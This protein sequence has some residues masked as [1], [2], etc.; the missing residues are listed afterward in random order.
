MATVEMP[1][2]EYTVLFDEEDEPIALKYKWF[3]NVRRGRAYV[4]SWEKGRTVY[5]H[6]L[7]LDAPKGMVVDHVNQNP[8]D[9][10]REN[11]R[12]CTRSQNSRNQTSYRGYSSPYKGVS[13]RKDGRWYAQIMDNGT[14]RNLG[15]HASE[16]DA[17]RAY[18][19]AARRIFG[20]Y[21][22]YNFPLEGEQPASVALND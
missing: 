15:I 4:Q 16:E 11:L 12:L 1:V 9:N 17:A 2:G 8:L 18:D 3:I 14:R 10:R 5:I 13:I 19:S 20:E 21:G 7:I 22:R 6:R